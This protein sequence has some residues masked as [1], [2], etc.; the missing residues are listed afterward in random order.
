MSYSPFQAQTQVRRMVDKP[1]SLKLSLQPNRR[2]PTSAKAPAGRLFNML[3]KYESVTD[4]GSTEWIKQI[5]PVV[6]QRV[7][8]EGTSFCIG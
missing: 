6:W 7:K 1:V 2:Y 4:T 3:D 8:P 5:S